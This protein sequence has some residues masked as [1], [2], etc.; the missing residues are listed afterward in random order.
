LPQ[1][2][3]LQN[4][5]LVEEMRTAISAHNIDGIINAVRESVT[6]FVD[7]KTTQTMDNKYLL[8]AYARRE[9]A[10]IKDMNAKPYITEIINADD[11]LKEDVG[12]AKG[13]AQKDFVA[14][15]NSVYAN[16]A[17]KIN[18]SDDPS[19]LMSYIDYSP[20]RVNYTEY[21]SMPTLSEMVDRPIQMAL[22]KQ[23][24]ILSDNDEFEE[25]VETALKKAKF[26]SVLKDAIFYSILSPRGS[27]VVPIKKNGGIA[28]NV[29][30][31]T[32]FAYGMGSSY[33][34]VTAPYNSVKVGDIYCM[35]AK[36]RHGISAFFTCPGYEP[37]FGIGLN[38]IPQLRAA[39][40]AWNLYVHVLKIL[41]VRSQV[42][43]ERLD[44]DIQTDTMLSNMRA[45]LQ[46]LSQTMG[47]STPIAQ[48]RG[49]TLDILNN[50]ISEGTTSVAG[51]FR[52]FIA[53]VTGL[54]PEYFFGGGNTNYSQA[55]FQIASTNENIRARYQV[56]MIEPILRFVINTL[57]R[58]DSEIAAME[59]KEDDFKIEFESIYE[60]TEAEK[61]DLIAK[62]TEILIR[63]RDY[64]ELA[65]AFKQ[66]DLLDED[67]D[68]DFEPDHDED[69]NED[70]NEIKDDSTEGVLQNPIGNTSGEYD[71]EQL[72]IG[73]EVEMEHTDNPE[74]AK[75]IAM[76]HL[77]ESKNYY[78]YLAEMEKKMKSEENK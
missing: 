52:D 42:I 37:L 58:N 61:V 23:P 47:V 39:A 26:Q 40:E 46:R 73:T 35:G 2:E 74:I 7:R 48:A 5:K 43:T 67:V 4:G 68:M 22:K 27:L 20:Y 17:L 12:K 55:A 14:A 11:Q 75:K 60:Q 1:S 50:N 31:D 36:L 65:P 13:K 34:G 16:G 77:K 53:A 29:F 72:K 18:T 57:I 41:L 71:P 76:D 8:N 63:Q 78:T 38:K 49:T 54:S 62:K 30:N 64:S 69:D 70:N 32:Q 28:L 19:L 66:L 45:Q 56:S 9:D 59:V 10:R 51:V 24:K 3:I 15:F 21:L 44:G 25:A 6:G 33:S